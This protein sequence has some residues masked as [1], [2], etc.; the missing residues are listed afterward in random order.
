MP[1]LGSFYFM[2]K[3]KINVNT[4]IYYKSLKYSPCSTPLH[5][6]CPLLVIVD[7]KYNQLNISSFIQFKHKFPT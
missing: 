5:L 6:N 7:E 2:E 3:L 4:C 1:K